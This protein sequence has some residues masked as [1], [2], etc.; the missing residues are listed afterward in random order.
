MVLTPGIWL[1]HSHSKPFT[2]FLLFNY[3][4]LAQLQVP[5]SPRTRTIRLGP[6]G[7][8]G[9]WLLLAPLSG[10][11]SP[12]AELFMHRSQSLALRSARASCTWDQLVSWATQQLS[13]VAIPCL[14][15][16][17][18]NRVGNQEGVHIPITKIGT[19]YMESVIVI[20]P[21]S[22]KSRA[23]VKHLSCSPEDLRSIPEL[24]V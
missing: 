12:N 6:E 8:P 24:S 11:P 21:D 2:R 3:C 19:K 10:G 23:V 4:K 13:P 7:I 16:G 14:A 5:E 20:T 9:T 15:T 17:R 18:N 22:L 1:S